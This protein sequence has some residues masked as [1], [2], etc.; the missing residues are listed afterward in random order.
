M[1]RGRSGHQW[2]GERR[3]SNRESCVFVSVTHSTVTVLLDGLDS[4]EDPLPSLA[5]LDVAARLRPESRGRSSD[6]D[7]PA[8]RKGSVSRGAHRGHGQGGRARRG[9]RPVDAMRFATRGAMTQRSTSSYRL[10]AAGAW[11]SCTAVREPLARRRF[12][13]RRLPSH[14]LGS[15]HVRRRSTGASVDVRDRAQ[16]VPRSPPTR[17]GRR[18][19][20]STT[21]LLTASQ[22][23][24]KP[25]NGGDRAAIARQMLGVVQQALMTPSRC[26]SAKPSS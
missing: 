18:A 6:F 8:G 4:A 24:D 22:R 10:C 25:D 12:D 23:F 14:P 26:A 15:R 16:L 3:V 21:A 2:P 7:G 19:H 13:A 1:A 20:R 11:L 5:S 9:E 17:A